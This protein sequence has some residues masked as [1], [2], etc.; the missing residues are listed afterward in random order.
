M[1]ESRSAWVV[2]HQPGIIYRKIS[3]NYLL[4]YY[5]HTNIPVVDAQHNWVS[6][7][8]VGKN[9]GLTAFAGIQS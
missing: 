1:Q 4:E 9:R 6:V 7:Q 3:I 8:E 2:K 5:V